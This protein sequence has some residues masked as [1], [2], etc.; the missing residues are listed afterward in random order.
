MELSNAKFLAT[1]A[2]LG[3][4]R[5]SLRNL[6]TNVDLMFTLMQEV[7][8][9]NQ[10]SEEEVDLSADILLGNRHEDGSWT[11]GHCKGTRHVSEHMNHCTFG[12]CDCGERICGYCIELM[13]NVHHV[14]DR[15][16]STCDGI[17]TT[18]NLKFHLS[19]L[20]E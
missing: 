10:P 16:C 14:D 13:A 7:I 19:Q 11:C 6:T 3:I 18:G 20:C 5:I 9:E 15:Q 4:I 12:N 17:L 2:L 1:K 8:D